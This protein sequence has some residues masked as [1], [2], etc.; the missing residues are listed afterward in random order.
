MT[1]GELNVG[2]VLAL[3]VMG[4]SLLESVARLLIGSEFP[5]AAGWARWSSP[6]S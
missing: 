3:L 4:F 1:K 5:L 6:S 2:I